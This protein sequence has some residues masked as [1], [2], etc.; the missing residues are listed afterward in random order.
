MS[1]RV[2][3]RADGAPSLLVV[4]ALV[5]LALVALVPSSAGADDAYE[6]AFL[7]R[8]ARAAYARDD[9]DRAFAH[10]A[11]LNA[12]APAPSALYNMALCADLG[13]HPAIAFA[14][15][16]EYLATDDA[17]AARRR[18]A[19][20][21]V[22]VLRGRLA[23]VRVESDPPGAMIGVDRTDLGDFGRTPRT[24]VVGAGAHTIL[25]TL[26]GHHGARGEVTAAVGEVTSLRVQLAPRL[27]RLAVVTT[28]PDAEV[29]VLRGEVEVA[30][31]TARREHELPV[32][33]YDLRAVAPGHEPALST[34]RVVEGRVERR[35]LV[36]R[37]LPTP[38]GRLLVSAG[39]VEAS[40][41]VDGSARGE[42]PAV[43][44]A[45]AV[46]EHDVEVRADGYRP[47]RRTVEIERDRATHV[48]VT[49]VRE[50]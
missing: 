19:E 11:S 34:V 25:L 10:F 39:D 26:D 29:V 6:A 43:L 35:T 49:L 3:L 4:L 37:A 20:R 9:Y 7:D 50:R 21:R 46:G 28:P 38:V 8:V 16:A 32:G 18:D 42:V 23:L 47:W 30:R 14:T 22:Q 31:L 27:G 40:V 33:R 24:I 45:M 2:P 48:T 41:V 36:A 13:G 44:D 1:A 5:V 15:F 17:D 12:I